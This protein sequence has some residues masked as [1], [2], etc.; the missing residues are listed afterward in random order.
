MRESKA[1]ESSQAMTPGWTPKDSAGPNDTQR[2]IMISNPVEPEFPLQIR[3]DVWEHAEN[4]QDERWEG[5]ARLGTEELF[6]LATP[7]RDEAERSLEDSV[8]KI[9]TTALGLFG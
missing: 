7:T 9:L 2:R 8:R 6:R 1:K 4:P 5:Y 3:L